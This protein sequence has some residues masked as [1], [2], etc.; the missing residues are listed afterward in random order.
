[1]REK[2]EQEITRYRRFRL[3]VLGIKEKEQFREVDIKNY[4]KYILKDG[5]MAEKRELLANLKSK[6]LLKN[7]TVYLEK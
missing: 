6:L 2:I 1:M 5:T 7:K 4:A 3:G